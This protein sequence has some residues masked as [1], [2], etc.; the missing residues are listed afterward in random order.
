MNKLVKLVLFAGL[1]LP[2]G[3][4]GQ[5]VSGTQNPNTEYPVLE[6][7]LKKSNAVLEDAEK[8][9]SPKFWLSRADLM[10]DIYNVNKKYVEG[11]PKISITVTMGKEKEIKQEE[12]EGSLFE[13]Y[14]YDRVNIVYKDGNYYNYIETNKIFDNPLDEAKKDLAK[15]QELDVEGKLAKKIKAA[16]TAL[17]ELYTHQGSRAYFYDNDQK[18]AYECFVSSLDINALPAADNKIDTS[19]MFNVGLI[20]TKLDL[21][22]EGIKYFDMALKYNYPEPRTYVYLKEDYLAL[23]DTAKGIEVLKEGFNKYPESLEIVVEL[24][25]YY[26]AANKSEEALNYLKIA[27]GKDPNNMSLIFAEGTLY[28]KKGDFDKAVEI[29]KK[30]TTIDPNYFNGYYNLGVLYYNR[31]QLYYKEADNASP[32]EYKKL[33]DLGDEQ[34]KFVVEPMEKCMKILEAKT[35]LTS[36]DKETLTVVYET[37]KSSYYRLQRFDPAYAEKV[38]E[39]KAKLGQ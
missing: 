33:Q 6:N 31:G 29:Y 26:L 24:I 27:Q 37:L 14:V 28:D 25:N 11:M 30:T 13:T 20:A 1:L 21:F 34:Y 12:K 15:A 19:L 9:A 7:K 8:T 5:E 3:L 22:Q 38:K 39:M 23:G 36:E 18:K 2:A 17:S 16:Y 4:Y 32:S 35:N 10:C